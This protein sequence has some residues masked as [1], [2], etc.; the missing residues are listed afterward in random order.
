MRC[1]V[2]LTIF[3]SFINF[4]LCQG[5]T[6]KFN[7][8]NITN[9]IQELPEYKVEQRRVDSIAKVQNI[10][11]G[12]CHINIDIISQVETKIISVFISEYIKFPEN[13]DISHRPLYVIQFDTRSKQIISIKRFA[14]NASL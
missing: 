7:S 6:I 8:E 4:G 9:M 3:Q 13:P 2:F 10:S 5:D 1:I 14:M 12:Q 11:L